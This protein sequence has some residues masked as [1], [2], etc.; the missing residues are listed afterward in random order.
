MNASNLNFISSQTKSRIIKIV[1]YLSKGDFKNYYNAN[2]PADLTIP[3]DGDSK[4]V[5]SFLDQK[6]P[7]ARRRTPNRSQGGSK[8][9]SI[10]YIK[11]HNFLGKLNGYDAYGNQ[12][13]FRKGYD[14]DYSR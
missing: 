10:V 14:K 3:R 2:Q 4:Y 11:G 1:T 13:D 5:P 12:D 7:D 8:Q 6:S 9:D